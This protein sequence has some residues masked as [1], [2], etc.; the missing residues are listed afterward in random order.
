MRL[1]FPNA[2]LTEP[3]FALQ[4]LFV[5]LGTI[6]AGLRRG[7]PGRRLGLRRVGRPHG[8]AAHRPE[9]ARFR[10]M[11]EAGLGTYLA[12][13]VVALVVGI[14]TALASRGPARTSLTPLAGVSVIA[15][16]GDGGGRH[17]PGRGRTGPAV[18]RRADG[19]RRRR[20][21]CC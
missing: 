13:G 9:S 15:L 11:L 18:V 20:R 4:V 7:G 12:V 21:R 19:H 1:A 16:Y 2:D 3:G 8:D 17:R 10:W 6:F 5:Q 14:V